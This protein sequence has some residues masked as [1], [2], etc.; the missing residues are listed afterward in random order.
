MRFIELH[1]FK[2][3][4]SI[5]IRSTAITAVHQSLKPGDSETVVHHAGTNSYFQVNET[6]EQVLALIEE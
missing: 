4:K 2:S 3:D 5:W 6:V 1:D